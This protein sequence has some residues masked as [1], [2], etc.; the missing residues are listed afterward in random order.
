[1]LAFLF[2]SLGSSRARSPTP[3]G[4]YLPTHCRTMSTKA[5]L[6]EWMSR[7]SFQLHWHHAESQVKFTFTWVTLFKNET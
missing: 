4:T 6:S 3:V 1:M 7:H 5:F 2:H